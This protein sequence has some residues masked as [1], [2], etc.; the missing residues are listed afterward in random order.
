MKVY[1][2]KAIAREWSEEH[3]RE[4][5][6]LWGVMFNGSTVWM[7]DEAELGPYSDVDL[8][9]FKKRAQDPEM[10]PRKILYKGV[11]IETSCISGK[12][13]ESPE[14]A[15]T[16]IAYA[17]SLLKPIVI[18]DPWG[19]LAEIQKVVLE[20]Y[21]KP[22]WAWRRCEKTAT[23]VRTAFLPRL[24]LP[25]AAEDRVGSMVYAVGLTQFIPM[26][27]MVEPLT[28]RKSGIAFSRMM[29]TLGREDLGELRFE[30]CGS[31]GMSKA[32]VESLL[33]EVTPVYDRAAAVWRTPIMCDNDLW[34]AARTHVIGGARD[35]IDRGYPREAAWWISYIYWFAHTALRTDA[36]EEYEAVYRRPYE[37]FAEA[38][39]L[40][41]V[42]A[43]EE[44]VRLAER[45][46][47]GV[48]KVAE[49][50]LK[51]TR[52]GAG[53][54]RPDERLPRRLVL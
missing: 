32:D 9:H 34:P 6:E 37:R 41:S 4:M 16:D 40:G 10:R 42:A 12:F 24:T 52:N 7:P 27:A 21:A 20:S 11:V 3:R 53:S 47:A 49:Q 18:Y 43:A 38:I 8:A 5:P 19:S 30:L 15:L 25:E 23:E 28:V 26:V 44:K 39:G 22:E 35:L 45:L 13:L 33:L 17:I 48:L 2:A 51:Q 36:P 50:V 54:S 14:G 29:A 31:A 1:E 46:L